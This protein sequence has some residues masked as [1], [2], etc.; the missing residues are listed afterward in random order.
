MVAKQTSLRHRFGPRCSG[1]ENAD[2]L[3]A[4]RNQ[5]IMELT[6][7]LEE[8]REEQAVLDDHLTTIMSQIEAARGLLETKMARND[9]LLAQLNMRA[10]L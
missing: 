1:E 8:I 9:S 2:K 4:Q 7:D 3:T 6:A 5:E 10:G